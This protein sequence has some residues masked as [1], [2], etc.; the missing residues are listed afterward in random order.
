MMTW[1]W[2]V[3]ELAKVEYGPVPQIGKRFIHAHGICSLGF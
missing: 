2:T 1:Y 3:V